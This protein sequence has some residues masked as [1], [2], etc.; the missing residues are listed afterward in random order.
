MAAAHIHTG[1]LFAALMDGLRAID[2]VTALPAPAGG[3]PTVSF[4]LSAE[5]PAA[6]ATAL[7]DQRIC[8]FAGDYYAYEYFRAMGLA[9]TGGAVRASLYHYNTLDEVRRFLAAVSDRTLRLR[10]GAG[11]YIDAHEGS[12]P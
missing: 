11:D 3:C 12:T 8:V 7:G 1:A 6:T 9:G 4:R 10:V 5:P 2:G